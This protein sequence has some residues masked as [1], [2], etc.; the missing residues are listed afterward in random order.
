MT[1]PIVYEDMRINGVIYCH[2]DLR[3][4]DVFDYLQG[5]GA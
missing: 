1:S 5:L 2:G 4:N 3:M